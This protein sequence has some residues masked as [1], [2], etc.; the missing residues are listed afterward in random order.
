[1][2]NKEERKENK[3][4]TVSE[5]E[6]TAKRYATE[7]GLAVI[8]IVT[9]MFTLIWGGSM[10][11]WSILLCMI[12]A[13]VGAVVSGSMGSWFNRAVDFIYRDKIVLIVSGVVLTIIGIFVPVL[14]FG[15]V[16]LIAGGAISVAMKKKK[17]HCCSS[18]IDAKGGVN[19][20]SKEMPK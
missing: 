9:A 15:L 10:M 8:F 18:T 11:V 13:I 5:L 16:G 6:G 1:M 7:I 12:F 4:F 2:E 14:I 20:S 19:P 3:G 17:G